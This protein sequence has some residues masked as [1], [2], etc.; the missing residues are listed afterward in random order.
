LAGSA[1]HLL[2]GEDPELA[3]AELNLTY[4]ALHGTNSARTVR[5]S[6][7]A[8]SGGPLAS[9]GYDGD[10]VGGSG[11][12]GGGDGD[13]ISTGVGDGRGG[14][15]NSVG[16]HRREWRKSMTN[17]TSVERRLRQ[18]Q[19]TQFSTKQHEAGPRVGAREMVPSLAQHDGGT[20]VEAGG[21]APSPSNSKTPL[22]L[23]L[24]EPATSGSTSA[25]D[26]RHSHST[27]AAAQTGNGGAALQFIAS[28]TSGKRTPSGRILV[29]EGTIPNITESGT[30]GPS[31]T[32]L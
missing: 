24:D 32:R 22:V 17:N 6:V 12:G 13:A 26:I 25:A 23:T 2:Q 14:S 9:L 7:K 20:R 28:T 8:K 4:Y 16:R 5:A 29:L 30:D 10:G 1:S 31:I 3:V 21:M 15:T 11:G 27:T 19:E 18:H